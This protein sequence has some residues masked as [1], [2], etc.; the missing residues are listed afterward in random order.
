[1]RALPG[2]CDYLL[3]FMSEANRYFLP[4]FPADISSI[5]HPYIIYISTRYIPCDSLLCTAD[6]AIAKQSQINI[7]LASLVEYRKLKIS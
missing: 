7:A 2:G 5:Y 3:I 1:M 4:I 6:H